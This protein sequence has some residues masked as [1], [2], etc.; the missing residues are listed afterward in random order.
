MHQSV[1]SQVSNVTED[2]FGRYLII[3]GSVLIKHEFGEYIYSPSTDEPSFFTNVFLTLASLPG[4][5][6]TA[7]DWNCTPHPVRDRS[8]GID[9]SHN[10]SRT[11]IDCFIRS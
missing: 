9:Q 11:T 8:T 5:Y 4:E 1:P 7:G 6:G 2:T 3:Q 10:R